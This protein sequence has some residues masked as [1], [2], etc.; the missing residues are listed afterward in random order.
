M[1]ELDFTLLSWNIEGKHYI[2]K[3][4]NIKNYLNKHDIVFIHETHCTREMHLELDNYTAIQHPCMLSS[5]DKPRGGCVMFIKHHLMKYVQGVDK[6]FHDA[7]LLYLTGNIIIAGFYIPPDNSK[8]YEDQFDILENISV[9]D[10]ENPRN[11]IVCGDLNARMGT[12][13]ELNGNS[14]QSNPDEYVNSHGHKLL[15][16]CKTN[17]LVPLNMLIKDKQKFDTGFTYSKGSCKSQNDWIMVSENYMQNIQRFNIVSELSKISDHIPIMMKAH[18][19]VN[20]SLDQVLENI[21]DITSETNNHSKFKKFKK[22][23]IDHDVFSNILKIYIAE[24]ESKQLMD[25]NELANEIDSAMRKAASLASKKTVKP[26]STHDSSITGDLNFEN[27]AAVEGR[28]EYNVWSKLLNDKDP[29]SVWRQIDFNGKYK[30]NAIKA[31]NTCDEFADFLEQRCSLPYEHTNYDDIESNIFN[32]TLDSKI[33]GEEILNGA[34]KMN[35]QSASRCGI[36]LYILMTIITSMLGILVPLFNS[37]FTGKYPN[38]WIAFI[39]CLPK[40][41]KLNIPCVRGISLKVILAKIYDTVIKNRLEKWF[42][43]PPEQTAYQTGKFTGLHVF[44]VRCLIS[45]CKKLRIPLFIGVTDFE[46]AFDFISRRNLFKK[47]VNIGIG[48]FM[49]RALIE[50]YK[51]TEAYV[52]LN[53]EY[54]HRLFITAGVLQGSASSTVLF[55]AYT[56]DIITLFQQN[57]PLEELLHLYHILLHADDSLILATSKESLIEKFKL[58]SKYCKDNNIK[59]QLRKCCFLAINSNETE[60]IEL[61]GEIIENKKEFVYLGSIITDSGDVTKDIKAEIKKKEKRF[62]QFFAFLSQNRNA[63]LVVKEKVL[64]ACVV[65]AVLTNCET[66]GNANID[67]LEKKYRRALKHLLG[68]RKSACNEFPYIEL[69]KPTL[70]SL[71]HKRQLKFYMDCM[72]NKD[73]PM[74]RYIIRKALDANSSFIKHYV[75][76][77]QQYNDKP[78][79]I[80][81]ASFTKLKDA[82][83]QKS[84]TQSKYKSFVEMNILLTR[85]DI[86][87]RYI[88][89]HK[90]NNVVR[91]RC[92]THNL[93]IE[94]GRHQGKSREERLCTCGH[95]EDEGHFLLRCHQ[96]THI[97]QKYFNNQKLNSNDI[98]NSLW[99]EDYVQELLECRKL[100]N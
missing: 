74:Q 86:Y 89:T 85:P 87:N 79:D 62:N 63:P 94:S 71:V 49:L 65:S 20:V 18:L 43:V 10:I 60:N 98:L 47:L 64:E 42:K 81:S 11:I 75:N 77:H 66:W 83:K 67:G 22:D 80:P 88:P 41:F 82:V 95:I 78:E 84:E 12:I 13:K 52:F 57:F 31:E 3:N 51:M 70:T 40:K 100:Y 2:L 36:P 15:E 27:V 9:F 90:L 39:S 53:G 7:I 68:L 54:S 73:F 30:S 91:L 46:A 4:S 34:K 29:T 92:V 69:G 5:V 6:N 1:N 32:P 56:S 97:R 45:I 28:K 21:T 50:M 26:T 8:Y 19:K 61:D 14:Y 24:I 48:M 99:T 96:Y 72:V 59:L 25:N 23:D 38:S 93:A 16:I 35:Q 76:L 33:T 44:F 58:L 17:N 37:I 55:M